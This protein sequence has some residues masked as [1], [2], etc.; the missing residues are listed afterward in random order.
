MRIMRLMI[1]ASFFVVISYII[2]ADARKISS[3]VVF[4]GSVPPV[5]GLF[6]CIYDLDG[7]NYE[8]KIV[9]SCLQR[10]LAS[11]YF[12]RGW[13]ESKAE[14][15]RQLV[16]FRLEAPSL[17]VSQIDLPVGGEQETELRSWLKK[18]GALSLGDTYDV[19]G[20][21]STSL[22]IEYF[23]RTKGKL[24]GVSVQTFLDYTRRVARLTY[25]IT[26][27]PR[28]PP[29]S[30]ATPYSEIGPQDVIPVDWSGVNEYAP[31][32][33]IASLTSIRPGS[34]HFSTELLRRDEEALK[35]SGLFENVEYRLIEE[36]A[37]RQVS[38]RI[39]GKALRTKEVS[40][41]GHGLLA[42]ASLR[43]KV[44]IPLVAGAIY[45]NSVAFQ[46]NDALRRY[47]EKE[48]LRFH[49]FEEVET[50][51]P[52]EVRVVFHIV[53][54]EKDQFQAEGNVRAR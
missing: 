53:A 36:E 16:V 20:Q 3:D 27:G 21:L 5:E 28:I 42:D 10:I 23:Y 32:P 48:G 41:R 44:F 12:E 37:H 38:L 14:N 40:I 13:V 26:E 29:E 9:D 18:S 51:S 2:H 54:Y 52:H 8:P 46:S 17:L 49:L 33:L 7:Q 6:R 22:S 47:L 24:A 4:N 25:Q 43:D 31:T 30:F 15:D 34:A 11:N 19:S 50:V 45:R 35:E 39:S 1:A